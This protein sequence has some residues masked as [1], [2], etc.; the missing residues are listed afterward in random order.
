MINADT[1]RHSNVR[2]IGAEN[3]CHQTWNQLQLTEVLLSNGFT[4][5]E[6][7]LA[8]TQ[9]I[10]RAVYP[11]SE[12]RTTRW[13]KENSA[14]CELT[15]YDMEKLTKD[16]LYQ[17]ALHLYKIKD[18][19]EKHLSQRTN[20][21]FDLQDKIVLYDITNTYFEGEKRNSKLARFGR[22]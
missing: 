21:L 1:M 16:N 10:A 13:I 11:A 7:Q 18:N 12:L 17:N 4:G 22:S 8:A 14:V 20:D 6:A 5:Q 9:V 15:G 19:L 2:E 3:I